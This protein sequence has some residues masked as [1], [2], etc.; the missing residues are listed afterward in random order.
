M[1]E[2][3]RVVTHHAS[4][5]GSRVVRRQDSVRPDVRLGHGEVGAGRRVVSFA[6]AREQNQK[7]NDSG[8]APSAGRRSPIVRPPERTDERA[9][10]LAYLNAFALRVRRRCAQ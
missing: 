9:F 10:S 6:A 7:T 5:E 8:H 3:Q 2:H 1:G 4:T